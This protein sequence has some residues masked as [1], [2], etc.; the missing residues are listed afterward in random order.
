MAKRWTMLEEE[1]LAEN[2]QAMTIK[3]LM[4]LLPGK[5]QDSINAKIKRLKKKEKIDGS[6]TRDVIDRA[7]RQRRK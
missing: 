7:Y 4:E 1:L 3:E 5:S 6:K 2:Y